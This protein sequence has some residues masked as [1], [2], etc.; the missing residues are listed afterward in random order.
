MSAVDS[1]NKE[2]DYGRRST[3]M[4]AIA[5]PVAMLRMQCLHYVI[6]HI[7]AVQRYKVDLALKS[8]EKFASA[9]IQGK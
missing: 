2:I 9:Y 4:F 6:S 1:Q 8:I 3:L 7:F 5:P